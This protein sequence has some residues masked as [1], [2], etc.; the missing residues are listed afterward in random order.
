[1]SFDTYRDPTVISEHEFRRLKQQP[2]V[3]LL[4]QDTLQI[5]DEDHTLM[6]ILQN[7]IVENRK[8]NLEKN[9]PTDTD[10]N[11][12]TTISDDN[13]LCGYVIPHPSEN[14]V[15]FKVLGDDLHQIIEQGLC[16]IEE[17]CL[18]AAER[19]ITLKNQKI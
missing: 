7:V 6:N 8:Y 14:I 10:S 18:I 3:K 2:K 13:F 12:N 19:L 1:M 15:H 5:S 11:K 4:S 17:M 16:D 9:V